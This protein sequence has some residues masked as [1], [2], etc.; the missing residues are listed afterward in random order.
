M[1]VVKPV[2]SIIDVMRSAEGNESSL[3]TFIRDAIGKQ[4][5]LSISRPNDNPVQWI[6][7]LHALDQPGTR[8]CLNES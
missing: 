8:Y 5:L 2:S 7:L 1:P 4:P 6:Q 3:D